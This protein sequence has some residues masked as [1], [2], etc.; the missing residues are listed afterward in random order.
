[1]QAFQNH[2]LKDF[3]FRLL[4]VDATT[5]CH[6]NEFGV[7]LGGCWGCLVRVFWGVFGGVALE[8]DSGLFWC[9]KKLIILGVQKMVQKIIQKMDPKK[10]TVRIWPN[11]YSTFFLVHFLDNFLRGCFGGV[12]GM[13]WEGVFGSVLGDI[14]FAMFGGDQR[15]GSKG[16]VKGGLSK[17]RR[18]ER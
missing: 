6:A 12:L 10:S 1:M 5:S 7:V 9:S 13:F 16:E 11:S 17:E 3:S 15:R 18:R 8:G 14:F 2:D 4:D